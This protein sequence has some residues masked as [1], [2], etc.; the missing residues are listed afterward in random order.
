MS[1][2]RISWVLAFFLGWAPSFG[3]PTPPTDPKAKAIYD[4]D[5][6]WLTHF[7]DSFIATNIRGEG[8]QYAERREAALDLVRER[9][10]RLAIPELLEE[11]RRG[12]FLSEE[13]C[14]LL[15]EWKAKQAIPTLKEVQADRKR[16]KNVREKARLAIQKI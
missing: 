6:E 5:K 7:P 14:G 2:R 9:T 4:H 11:L 13:I 8:L 10:I 12:S 15:A 3:H 16:P 1:F